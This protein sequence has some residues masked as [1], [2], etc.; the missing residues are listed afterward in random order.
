MPITNTPNNNKKFFTNL[1]LN[2]SDPGSLFASQLHTTL[3]MLVSLQISQFDL[4]PVLLLLAFLTSGIFSMHQIPYRSWSKMAASAATEQS[5][6]TNRKRV[7]VLF[8]ILF[9][10]KPSCT[11]L[12]FV[13]SV[14][15]NTSW[16]WFKAAYVPKI[17]DQATC[18][19]C[20]YMIDQLRC[21]F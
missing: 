18:S 8:L 1:K 4:P 19:S 3:Y 11:T 7:F 9:G 21:P 15:I 14:I 6:L 16:T 17:R 2:S 5:Y 13:H 12:N 10:M 20:S